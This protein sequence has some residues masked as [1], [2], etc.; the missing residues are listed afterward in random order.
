MTKTHNQSSLP[1]NFA[2][3]LLNCEI[4]IELNEIIPKETIM[5]VLELYSKGM[6]YF[7]SIRSYKYMY[8]ER[9]MNT[10]MRSPKIINSMSNPQTH[11]N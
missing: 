5:Q 6:E 11:K 1:K 8:F 2:E 9:R 7:E 3:L 10:M 4:E